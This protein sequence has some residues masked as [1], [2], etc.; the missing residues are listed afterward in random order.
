MIIFLIQLIDVAVRLF[1]LLILAHIVLSYFMD[2][3]HPVRRQVDRI[4]EPMLTPIRRVVPLVG[5]IDFSPLVLLISV[6]F[7]G[8]I[9]TSIL[10]SFL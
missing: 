5:M 2:P 6:Q 9:V 7:V 8:M 10:R 4:V 1:V 3:F